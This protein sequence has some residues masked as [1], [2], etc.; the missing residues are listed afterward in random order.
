MIINDF[1]YNLEDIEYSIRI[2]LFS[3]LLVNRKI[4]AMMPVTVVH[5][6]LRCRE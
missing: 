3:V 5:D 1:N 2:F 4:N 6:Q